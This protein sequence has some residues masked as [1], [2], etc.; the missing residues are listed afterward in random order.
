[1]NALFSSCV[2]LPAY[3]Y[4]PPQ[5]VAR[6]PSLPCT[7]ALDLTSPLPYLQASGNSST[8]RCLRACHPWRSRKS[9][10]EAWYRAR[11]YPGRWHW[12]L[13]GQAGGHS[14]CP[15]CW[16]SSLGSP[17]RWAGCWCQTLPRERHLSAAAKLGLSCPRKR[18]R[19]HSQDLPLQGYGLSGTL[20]EY[21]FVAFYMRQFKMHKNGSQHLRK[22]CSNGNKSPMLIY[23]WVNTGFHV[24]DP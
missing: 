4:L 24:L 15:T 21:V 7:A 17:C 18:P 3:L 12:S 6:G 13:S 1:M 19:A 14:S 10:R 23:L 11:T 16:T 2:L 20:L 9:W 8:T 22:I 5:Y